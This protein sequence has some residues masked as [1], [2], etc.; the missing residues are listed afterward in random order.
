MIENDEKIEKIND[1]N[2]FFQDIELSQRFQGFDKFAVTELQSI[3][4]QNKRCPIVGMTQVHG[5]IGIN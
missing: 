5:T 4:N 1:R 3:P 2:H